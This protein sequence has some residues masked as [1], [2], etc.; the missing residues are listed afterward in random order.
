MCILNK[1]IED[2]TLK[3]EPNTIKDEPNFQE[4]WIVSYFKEL[5]LSIKRKIV[6]PDNYLYSWFTQ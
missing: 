6:T 1:S 5:Y 3:N 2:L 4:Y